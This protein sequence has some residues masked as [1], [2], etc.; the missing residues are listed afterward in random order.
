MGRISTISFPGL[1]IGEF[2][3]NG[4]ALSF[5]LWG[6]PVTIMWY[7]IIICLGIFAGLLILRG[8]RVRREFPLMIS[9]I[10]P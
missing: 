4:V 10:L 5:E 7:G 9:W 8:G 3:I 1:G 2:T 6:R